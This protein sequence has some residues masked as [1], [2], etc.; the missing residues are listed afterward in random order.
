MEDG[1]S[2]PDF[3]QESCTFQKIYGVPNL[4][5]LTFRQ[6]DRVDSKKLNKLSRN[7]FL[8]CISVLRLILVYLITGQIPYTYI[9]IPDHW[10]DSIHL[11]YYT[12]H[13][14][15]RYKCIKRTTLA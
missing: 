14:N 7:S 8:K 2:L 4:E 11:Y 12:L 9:S 6:N 5:R 13:I 1:I 15:L 10:T 3:K